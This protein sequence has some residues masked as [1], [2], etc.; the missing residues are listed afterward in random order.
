MELSELLKNGDFFGKYDPETE[1]GNVCSHLDDCRQGSLF[2]AVDGRHFDGSAHI[3]EAFEKGAKAVVTEKRIV[4]ENVIRCENVLSALAKIHAAENGNPQKDLTLVGLTGTNGKT[5][6]SYILSHILNFVGIKTGIIGSVNFENTT[7]EPNVFYSALRDFKNDG[8][9]TVVCEISSQ[10]LDRRRV[11]PCRF[12]VG[13][14]LN[15]GRDHID[16]HQT[17]SAYFESKKRLKSLSDIFVVNV[18]DRHAASLVSDG[19]KTFSL[20]SAADYVAE[21]VVS[22]KDGTCFEVRHDEKTASLKTNLVGIF[23]VYNILAAISA[24]GELGIPVEEAARAFASPITVPGRMEKIPTKTPFS[25]FVDYAHTP[26]ALSAALRTLKKATEGRLIVVFGCGGDRDREKRPIMGKIA[27]RFADFCIVTSDNPRTEDPEAIIRDIVSGADG[28][29]F[30]VVPKRREAIAFAISSARK[31]DTVLVA[32]KG[33]EK[34]Q[35]VGKKKLPFD[36]ARVIVE[37]CG[38]YER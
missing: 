34:Y 33:H 20:L 22:E 28:K 3:R 27:A 36:D 4:G 2:V 35:T 38:R 18:D 26:Q 37:E 14:F 1:I 9:E 21:N 19:V 15:F 32:G 8:T 24:A 23:N 10:G 17:V 29:R 12:R 25:V 5:S 6:T 31:G 7:P 11:D 30:S 13:E 16:Y